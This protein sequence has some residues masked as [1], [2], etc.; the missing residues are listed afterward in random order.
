VRGI[1]PT[2]LNVEEFFNYFWLVDEADDAH[3]SLAFG[4]GKG[5]SDTLL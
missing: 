2:G 3:F 4:T 1:L 5:M